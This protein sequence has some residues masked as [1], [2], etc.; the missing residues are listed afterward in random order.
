[1]TT[2]DLRRAA[3]SQRK[4]ARAMLS[5]DEIAKKHDPKDLRRKVAK[6]VFEFYGPSLTL[7]AESQEGHVKLETLQK[8]LDALVYLGF[9][10]RPLAMQAADIRQFIKDDLGE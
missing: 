5:R 7:F 8:Y 1:M 4:A 2:D 3:M 10:L 6:L 9:T